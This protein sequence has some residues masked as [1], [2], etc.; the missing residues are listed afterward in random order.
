MSLGAIQALKYLFRIS[1]PRE[2]DGKIILPVPFKMGFPAY[3][4]GSFQIDTPFL[5]IGKQYPTGKMVD[6]QVLKGGICLFKWT[7][8]NNR[9]QSRSFIL[10]TS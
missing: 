7:G 5:Q 2:S 10:N 3:F 1:Y 9:F 8:K 6:F 4:L